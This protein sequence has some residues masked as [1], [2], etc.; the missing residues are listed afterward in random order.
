MNGRNSTCLRELRIK[1]CQ[2]RVWF[3]MALRK[4]IRY[5]SNNWCERLKLYMYVPWLD[6]SIL[7]ITRCWEMLISI[8]LSSK[9]GW[10]GVD[11]HNSSVLNFLL[12]IK[13]Q[14]NDFT[15]SLFLRRKSSTYQKFLVVFCQQLIHYLHYLYGFKFF[16]HKWKLG[17]WGSTEKRYAIS[18][19]LYRVV[20]RKVTDNC[21]DMSRKLANLHKKMNSCVLNP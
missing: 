6:W 18:T 21:Q 7:R 15:T 4:F 16:Y 1:S 20:Q 17:A 8:L 14:D 11:F 10:F 3:L 13:T 5:L 12:I 2:E 9:K 19:P